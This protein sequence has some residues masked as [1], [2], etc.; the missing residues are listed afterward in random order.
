MNLLLHGLDAP[1]DRS[2]QRPALQALRDRREGPRRRDPHQSALRRRGGEGHPGQLPRG[3]A[4]GR[5]GA[6]LPPAHHAQAAPPADGWHG[7]RRA[8]QSSC[9]TARCSAMAYARASRRNC[10]RSSTCTPS[11]AC[12][13]ACSRPIHQHPDQYLCSS[14][15]PARRRRSGITSIRLPEGRKNYTK[16]QP[17]QFEEFKP[18]I[19]WWNKREENDRAWKVP[20]AEM[21]ATSATSIAEIHAP[22]KI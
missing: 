17:I 13:T 12:P 1:T 21:L 14:T 2:G 15:A 5:N 9:R 4:D 22:R 10:S 3:P 6:A 19:A 11:C 7:R 16:T 18:C 20:V 8:R